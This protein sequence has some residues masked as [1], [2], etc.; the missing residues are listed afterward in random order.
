MIADERVDTA[1]KGID[2]RFRY[3]TKPAFSDFEER[4]SVLFAI[5]IGT[6]DI[7]LEDSSGNVAHRICTLP[8]LPRRSDVAF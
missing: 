5:I 7:Q 6:K 8:G 2:G 4:R 3:S 1:V